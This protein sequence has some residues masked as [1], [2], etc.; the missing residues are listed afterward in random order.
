M[1][2][3]VITPYHDPSSRYLD[4]C[5][6]SVQEQTYKNIIHVTVGDGCKLNNPEEFN[7]VYD[8]PLPKNINNFGD[9]PRSIGVI[10][11]FSLG[12]DA[13]AFLDSD[14][15]Y[16][17]NHIELMVQTVEKT[18]SDVATSLRYLTHLDG[19]ILGVCPES[20][21]IIFCDTNCLLIT[22]RLAEEAGLW[23]LI[24]ADMHVIDD[25]V[26]WDTLIHA[27][28]RIASTNIASV[29]YRTAF[30]FHYQMFSVMPP[31]QAKYGSAIA[32]LGDVINELQARAKQKASL[33][34]KAR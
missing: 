9:S 5:L 6:A 23:W 2:I 34:R 21:G 3:A 32:E 4:Q 14:N 16:A 8:I 19:S 12:V 10:Y 25:R 27:T 17:N 7:N 11:A 26:M 15:W 13:V 31:E 24:P 33:R 18:G 1:K 28:D 20:D 22:R 29:Y 30:A